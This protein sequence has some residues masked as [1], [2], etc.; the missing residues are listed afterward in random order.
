MARHPRVTVCNTPGCPNLNPCQTPGHTKT[1]W[2]GSTRRAELPPDWPS[3]TARIKTR[4]NNQ[5]TQCGSSHRLEVD[6]V[7][8]RHQHGD[9]NLRTLCHDCHKKHTSK[10]AADARRRNRIT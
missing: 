10:Q 9:H 6:H 1:P 5:C 7:G 8:D 4:D 2:A 3:I